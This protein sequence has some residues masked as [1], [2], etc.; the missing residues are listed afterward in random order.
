V[1][2]ADRALVA[3]MRAG[4]Q[5]A[6]EEFVSASAPRLTAFA[7]RRS[8]LDAASL[9]DVVQNTLIKAVRNLASY[10]SEAAL[11]TWLTEICRHELVDVQR[12]AARRPTQVSLDE[13]AATRLAVAALR[14]PEHQEPVATLEAAAR[15][16]AVMQVLASLPERYFRALEA[17]Y[18]DGLS[19]DEIAK[20]LG[21]TMIATQS[22]LARARE[23]FRERWQG[24]ADQTHTGAS[25]S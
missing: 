20:E 18:G 2:E 19:V 9:E 11:F 3:R 5:R 15:A 25:P 6:F 14:A 17:K 1:Y 13:T 22:L 8:S 12:K 7:T 21:L 16:A 24:T 4:D 23:A 10:R